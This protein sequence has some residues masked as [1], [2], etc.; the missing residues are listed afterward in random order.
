MSDLTKVLPQDSETVQAIYAHWKQR[1]ESEKPRRYLGGSEIGKECE[2]QLW[3]GF[4]RCT[5]PNFDGRL[6]RLFNRG[7]REE[8]TFVAELKGIGCEVHE[9]DPTTGKQFEVVDVMGHF[10]GHADGVALGLPEAPKTW[11]LLEMKTASA[12]SFAKTKRDGCEKD[13]PQH[14]AQMQVYM[15]L[16]GLKRALYIV[17]NKDND[18]LYSERIRYDAKRAQALIDKARR[19]IT[20]TTAPERISDRPDAFACKFCDARELCHG[21]SE[22]AVN[23]PELDC[24]QCVH[25]TPVEGGKWS[26]KL[27]GE[28]NKVCKDHLFLP[29]LIGFAEPTD[30]LTNADGSDVIEFTNTEDGTIWHHGSDDHAGQYPSGVLLTTPATLLL[31]GLKATADKV[32]GVNLEQRY[33]L[34]MDGVERAWKGKADDLIDAFQQRFAVPMSNPNAEQSGDGWH[35]AEFYPHGCA[36]IYGDNAEIRTSEIPY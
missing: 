12:K 21:T 10:K 24:R 19:I 33:S 16:L 27:H 3:Y 5:K 29:A 25:A 26:C 6:Y 34:D 20:S 9:V 1:G 13:K 17:V 31:E 23:V 2:R 14:F 30:A 15:H 8:E 22:V 4:R 32:T 36:I 35:A 28:A 18:E 11:H 7:H